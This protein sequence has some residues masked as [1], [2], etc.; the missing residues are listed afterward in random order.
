ME[1][2]KILGKPK[3]PFFLIIGTSVKTLRI[4]KREDGVSTHTKQLDMGQMSSITCCLK[5]VSET[6]GVRVSLVLDFV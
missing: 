2:V 6:E 1:D 5:R 4:C 3:I